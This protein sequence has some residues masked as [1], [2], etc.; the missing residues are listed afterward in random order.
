[1]IIEK[2][3]AKK[4]DE[5]FLNYIIIEKI[6]NSS[7]DLSLFVE[8]I[9]SSIFQDILN[10]ENSLKTYPFPLSD[11][12]NARYNE[13]QDKSYYM[14]LYDYWAEQNATK[15]EINT[16]T[17]NLNQIK[18]LKIKSRE[19][20]LELINIWKLIIKDK[21][22]YIIIKQDNHGLIDIEIKDTLSVK[23]QDGV[24]QTRICF[25]IKRKNKKKRKH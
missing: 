9:R 6:G 19:N 2:I 20:L 25:R 7:N 16:L 22:E 15:K 13:N 21:P 14:E 8:A 12:W 11:E 4:E 5:D 24:Y 3:I 23:D 17:V 18:S 10:Y 1:M